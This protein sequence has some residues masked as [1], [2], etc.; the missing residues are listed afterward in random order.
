MKKQ[1]TI[2]IVSIIALLVTIIFVYALYIDTKTTPKI[3]YKSGK[4]V[5]NLEGSTVEGKVVPG[6][7]LI[8]TPYT[9]TNNSTVDSQLR[10]KLLITLDDEVL[11]YN[12]ERI[13]TD[14]LL[15]PTFIL[16]EG[17]YYYGG[18][19]GILL[20]TNTTPITIISQLILDGNF[21]KNN[22]G[23][24]PEDKDYSNKNINIKFIFEAKQAN[25]VT[26]QILGEEDIDFTTGLERT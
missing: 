3:T 2:L 9:L 7:N 16:V 18:V 8:N 1:T 4:V 20:S 22:Y 14:V 25:H 23:N 24:N 26:W 10:I 13:E 12:D 11:S 17:Y 6:Q 15:E 5:Y 19:D 21:V